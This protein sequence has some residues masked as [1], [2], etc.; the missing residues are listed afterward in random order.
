[1]FPPLKR[2]RRWQAPAGG[3]PPHLAAPFLFVCAP[4]LSSRVVSYPPHPSAPRYFQVPMNS[5]FLPQTSAVTPRIQILQKKRA[6][7]ALSYLVPSADNGFFMPLV[8]VSGALAAATTALGRH[9]RASPL[10][11][12][13]ACHFMRRYLIQLFSLRFELWVSGGIGLFSA[14]WRNLTTPAD[15]VYWNPLTSSWV[16]DIKVPQAESAAF[17]QAPSLESWA[18]LVGWRLLTP[19]AVHLDAWASLKAYL[20]PPA[21]NPGVAPSRWLVRY[22]FTWESVFFKP[23]QAFGLVR[24]PKARRLPR[25][26]AKRLVKQAQTRF[27]V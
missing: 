23:A 10:A 16:F 22:S 11:Q 15:E 13:L 7:L 24:T 19:G 9:H 26:Q 6:Q 3:V 17:Q 14:F 4:Q 25:R 18:E 5:H 21:K 27:W 1:M 8:L 2:L 20:T 12:L